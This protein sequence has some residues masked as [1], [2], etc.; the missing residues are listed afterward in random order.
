VLTS[1]EKR[2]R[3]QIGVFGRT[4][5]GKTSLIHALAGTTECSP[6]ECEPQTNCYETEMSAVG[7][8]VFLDTFGIDLQ[9]EP[10]QRTLETAGRID[11][12]LI[13]FD[14]E[15]D[16]TLEKEL[17]D[18]LSSQRIP[19]IGVVNKNDVRFVDLD[20]LQMIY[21]FPFIRVSATQRKY[22]GSLFTAMKAA[23]TGELEQHKAE[24]GRI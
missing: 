15:A 5:T 18:N 24:T 17:I 21:D 11:L 8:V 12:A 16:Y 6:C 19:I 20:P 13:I 10:L 1:I 22:L 4:G 2:K 14:E 9:G 3:L 7:R 23:L